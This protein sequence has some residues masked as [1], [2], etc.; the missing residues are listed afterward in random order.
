MSV[1]ETLNKGF[2]F[3][4]VCQL[5]SDLFSLPFFIVLGDKMEEFR[6]SDMGKIIIPPPLKRLLF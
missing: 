1:A 3:F 6:F 2:G 5:F 4:F